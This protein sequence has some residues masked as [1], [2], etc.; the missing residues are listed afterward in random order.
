MC[1][2]KLLF[3]FYLPQVAPALVNKGF[4]KSYQLYYPVAFA[5]IKAN[6]VKL[7]NRKEKVKDK[8]KLFTELI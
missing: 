1:W 5:F 6:N 2:L 8:C 7:K 4:L 3:S